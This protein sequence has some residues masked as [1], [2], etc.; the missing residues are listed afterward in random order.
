MAQHYVQKFLGHE[1]SQMT[2]VYAHI[3]DQTLKKE[4]AKYQG[5]IVDIAGKVIEERNSDVDNTDLQWFKK[6]IQAQALPNGSCA[7]PVISQG[8]PH[9]NACLTCTSFRTTTEFLDQHKQ[10]LKHTEEIIEKARSN[11]WNRQLEMNEKVA[12]N[13]TNIINSL[14]SKNDP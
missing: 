1:S 13:L 14:E 6:N 7:L 4:F 8:C 3:H 9:A 2:Q 10:Q 11:G 5:K 12:Q